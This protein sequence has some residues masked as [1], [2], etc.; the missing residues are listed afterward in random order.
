M[1]FEHVEV[2]TCFDPISSKLMT[3]GPGRLSVD[4]WEDVG[5]NFSIVWQLEFE[6]WLLYYLLGRFWVLVISTQNHR[7]HEQYAVLSR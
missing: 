3:V 5:V 7:Y 1:S 2:R 6:K 4:Y